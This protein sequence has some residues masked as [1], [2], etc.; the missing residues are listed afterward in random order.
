MTKLEKVNYFLNLLAVGTLSH[1]NCSLYLNMLLFFRQVA[2][3][4]KYVSLLSPGGG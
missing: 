1:S 3:C 4:N 2:V